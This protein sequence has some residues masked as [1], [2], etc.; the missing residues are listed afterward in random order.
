MNY[1]KIII[2]IL[3]IV[4]LTTDLFMVFGQNIIGPY[5][6]IF[7]MVSILSGIGLIIMVIINRKSTAS[8]TEN[9]AS[10]FDLL[11][12]T[13]IETKICNIC[14]TENK[15][16]AKYCKKCGNDLKEIICPICKTVNPYDQKYCISCD[17]ILQNK[18]RHL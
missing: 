15:L 17:T 14:N 1:K 5:V 18:K 8:K 13:K 3:I 16:K 9:K 4:L 7:A 6:L 12:E 10:E 11:N 2:A